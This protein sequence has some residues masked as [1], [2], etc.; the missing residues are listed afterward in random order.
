M[1]LRYVTQVFAM[2]LHTY[3]IGVVEERSDILFFY[4]YEMCFLTVIM[5]NH[6]FLREV[7]LTVLFGGHRNPLCIRNLYHSAKEIFGE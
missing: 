1:N 7:A 2:P 4:G 3:S 6:V 5:V